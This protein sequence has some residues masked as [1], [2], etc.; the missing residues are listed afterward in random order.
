MSGTA[1]KLNEYVSKADATLAE[2]SSVTQYEKLK[3]L[4]EKTGVSKVFFFVGFTALFCGLL[5]LA[6]GAKLMVD[7]AG[8][9]YPAY[10]SF[11]ALDTAETTDDVQWLTYWVVFATF[12]IIEGTIGFVTGFIPFY[13]YIKI[14][15]LVWLYHP[16]FMGATVLYNQAI[17]PLVLPMLKGN[18]PTEKKSE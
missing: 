4:E 7:L 15:F 18:K 6:G 1:G 8:F 14:A 3:E 10:M 2:Y 5:Y 9:L 17:R 16:Q 13:Y 12:S 11:K